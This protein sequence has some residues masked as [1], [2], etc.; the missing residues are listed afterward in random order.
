M[1]DDKKLPPEVFG[2]FCGNINQDSAQKLSN[3]FGIASNNGVT[4]IHLLY[5]STGGSVSDGIFLYNLFKSL[6]L[7]LILY[8][9]GQVS[10]AAA[11]AYLGA[12]GRKT[13]ASATFMLHRSTNAPQVATVANMTALVKNL[14]LDDQR[15]EAI[16]REHITLPDELWTLFD[17]HDIYL[18]AA[19]SIQYGLAQEIADF[20]PPSDAKIFSI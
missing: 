17:R 14:S 19:E 16:L 8:N 2:I 4:H 13:S 7:K 11:V 9:A 6:P 5:Q 15:T 3:A 1:E 18:S 20:S 10:S 12:Q